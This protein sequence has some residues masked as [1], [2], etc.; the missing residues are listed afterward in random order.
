MFFEARCSALTQLQPY[1][2]IASM[3]RAHFRLL[4]GER[5]DRGAERLLSKLGRVRGEA[6]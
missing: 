6:G 4:P 3:L 1:E 2:P 5:R